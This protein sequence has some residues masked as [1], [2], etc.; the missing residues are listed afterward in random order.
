MSRDHVR[1][2][3]LYNTALVSKQK[4]LW[5]LER[6][7]DWGISVP[8]SKTVNQEHLENV[9]PEFF[10]VG[11]LDWKEVQEIGKHTIPL[12]T[13]FMLFIGGLIC[14]HTFV[15]Q[16]VKLTIYRMLPKNLLRR[17]LMQRLH[18][19]PD[20]VSGHTVTFSFFLLR[21]WRALAKLQ[22]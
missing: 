12:H 5:L 18:L 22:S 10:I 17:T 1:S 16:I 21:R 11:K 14:H 20:D 6:L 2:S 7:Y 8:S 19:F 15:P 3:T 4:L 13:F 9:M